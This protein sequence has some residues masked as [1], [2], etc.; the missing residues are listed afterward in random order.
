MKDR[1]VTVEVK[2]EG[3]KYT[4]KIRSTPPSL[5]SHLERDIILATTDLIEYIIKETKAS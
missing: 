1:D 4:R 5:L 2:Y 3:I